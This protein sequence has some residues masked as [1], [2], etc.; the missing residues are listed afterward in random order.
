MLTCM[1]T[2]HAHNLNLISTH[3]LVPKFLGKRI[4]LVSHWKSRTKPYNTFGDLCV[5]EGQ[6]QAFLA[7]F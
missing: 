7:R 3:K 5:R 6:A 1:H 2:T 4:T